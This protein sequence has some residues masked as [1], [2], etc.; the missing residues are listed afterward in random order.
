MEFQ[1]AW[2]RWCTAA[3]VGAVACTAPVAGQKPGAA[4]AKADGAGSDGLSDAALSDA[5]VTILPDVPDVAIVPDAQVPDVPTKDASAGTADIGKDV[6][7]DI[8]IDV[9]PPPLV[10]D[11]PECVS[12][13]WTHLASMNKPRQYASGDWLGDKF[14]V[15]GGNS[16]LY[17][18]TNPTTLPPKSDGIEATGEVYD[19]K[20]D[21]WTMLPQAP[22]YPGGGPVIAGGGKL[23]VYGNG[24]FIGPTPWS[25]NPAFT[26]AFDPATS[27]W[28]ALPATNSPGFSH[29]PQV[30]WTGMELLV[31]GGFAQKGPGG[32]YDPV[33]DKW[34]TFS[35]TP[36]P[37]AW[38]LPSVWTG[39][40]WIIPWVKTPY[41]SV[42]GT[43]L[44]NDPDVGLSYTPATKIWTTFNAE[45]PPLATYPSYPDGW[46]WRQC[47]PLPD[48]FIGIGDKYDLPSRLLR[49]HL[50]TGQFDELSL[51]LRMAGNTLSASLEV[52]SIHVIGD[53]LIVITLG[54]AA[55]EVAGIARHLPTGNWYR[56]PHPHKGKSRSDYIAGVHEATLYLAGGFGFDPDTYAQFIWKDAWVLTGPWT[57]SPGKP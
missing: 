33:T 37:E 21:T 2:M 13:T 3:L 24:D 31:W 11:L 17:A 29:W 9:T 35:G 36:V 34:T 23:Y 45:P 22:L 43:S 7:L 20:T 50:D 1:V 19:P 6:A 40:T 27:A 47:A 57:N 14:Y 54:I 55:D 39:A 53:W 4:D 49:Y 42:P 15:W 5:D 38:S 30:A 26:A 10:A 51:P 25:T 8:A 18:G 52:D 48:G 44:L 16:A 32:S 41:E 56:L 12:C 28:T 46:A